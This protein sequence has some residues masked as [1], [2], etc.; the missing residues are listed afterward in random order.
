MIKLDRNNPTNGPFNPDTAIHGVTYAN[1]ER[2][3]TTVVQIDH[4]TDVNGSIRPAGSWVNI[5]GGERWAHD[6]VSI[7]GVDSNGNRWQF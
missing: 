6:M 4:G 3:H 7:T 2:G 5:D 1:E